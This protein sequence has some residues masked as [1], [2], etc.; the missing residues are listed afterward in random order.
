MEDTPAVLVIQDND[1]HV[2]NLGPAGV[3]VMLFVNGEMSDQRKAHNSSS[4]PYARLE[5]ELY[6]TSLY[7]PQQIQFVSYWELF[8]VNGSLEGF[9]F[10][11]SLN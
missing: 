2:S 10:Q 3:L 11:L 6:P 8:V 4:Y 7:R 5:A 1:N 9:I